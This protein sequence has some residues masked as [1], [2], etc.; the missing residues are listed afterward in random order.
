[1]LVLNIYNV[2]VFGL[3]SVY[4]LAG[5]C[6][7]WE[8]V[9]TVEAYSNGGVI[10]DHV[11]I[12]NETSTENSSRKINMFEC[13]CASSRVVEKVEG[14]ESKSRACITNNHNRL[15]SNEII[16]NEM[17][18]AV[19]HSGNVSSNGNLKVSINKLTE[20]KYMFLLQSL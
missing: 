5:S 18:S 13:F 14:D 20:D 17:N 11:E 19:K 12:K 6:W 2:F 4:H 8:K 15:C 9:E 7:C 3:K 10:D 1:M 16:T